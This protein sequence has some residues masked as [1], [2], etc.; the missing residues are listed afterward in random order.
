MN[1][2]MAE[3]TWTSTFLALILSDLQ[4]RYVEDDVAHKF[5]EAADAVITVPPL[6]L[7]I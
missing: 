1:K 4:V 2:H 6:T 3:Q 5:V 7:E